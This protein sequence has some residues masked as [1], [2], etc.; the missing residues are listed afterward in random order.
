MVLILKLLPQ[1][2]SKASL[3]LNLDVAFVND[4]VAQ[5]AQSCTSPQSSMLSLH[6][7]KRFYPQDDSAAM[8]RHKKEKSKLSFVDGQIKIFI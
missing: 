7:S 6:S 3:I 8:K 5:V 1:D 2:L 4:R